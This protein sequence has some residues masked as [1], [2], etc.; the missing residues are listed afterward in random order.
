MRI[1]RRAGGKGSLAH[2]HAGRIRIDHRT[3]SL[4]HTLPP[5]VALGHQQDFGRADISR[6]HSRSKSRP[7]RLLYDHC[8]CH[9][10]TRNRMTQQFLELRVTKLSDD[11]LCCTEGMETQDL[12]GRRIIRPGLDRAAAKFQPRVQ[13]GQVTGAVPTDHL[14]RFPRTA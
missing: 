12:P 9:A 4:F 2:R 13:R 1:V 10:K 11:Y 7:V 6:Q 8:G 5:S 14:M 3:T